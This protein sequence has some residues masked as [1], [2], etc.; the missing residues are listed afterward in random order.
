MKSTLILLIGFSILPVTAHELPDTG[1]E[2]SYT[3]TPGED[4]DYQP[5]ASQPSYTDNGDGTTTDNKTGLM[6]VKDG[7]S[8]GCNNGSS[9]T[10]EAALN[11]CEGLTYAGYSD[12]RLPNRRELMSIVDYGTSVPAINTAY[13]SNTQSSWYWTST[14]YV[15]STDTA[16][17]VDFS[18]GGVYNFNKTDNY[19]VR[20]VRAGP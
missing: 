1:Q 5:A 20:C 7:N 9:L 4:H 11:F 14:T 19:Y 8:A 6:W 18:N 17:Y 2:Q 12:W 10:W 16:W 15:P 13:F 3:T